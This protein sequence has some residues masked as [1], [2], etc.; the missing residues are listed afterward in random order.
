MARFNHTRSDSANRKPPSRYAWNQLTN[1]P[2]SNVSVLGLLTRS[3]PPAC[4]FYRFLP[5]SSVKECGLDDGHTLCQLSV[6]TPIAGNR[7]TRGA[8]TEKA[9][10]QLQT[11]ALATSIPSQRPTQSL[12]VKLL[13]SSRKVVY[14]RQSLAVLDLSISHLYLRQA[15][16]RVGKLHKSEERLRRVQLP[17]D[18]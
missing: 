14:N 13:R 16:R 18:H 15:R 12:L 7:A 9:Q 10:S 8:H 3:I 4:I 6:V 11:K 2:P 5:T 1:I 17:P